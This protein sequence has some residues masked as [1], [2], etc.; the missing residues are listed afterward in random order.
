MAGGTR[1][2][3][4]AWLV[5][6]GAL[7]AL[8]PSVNARLAERVGGF[9]PSALVSFAVG[10]VALA[11]IVL[12]TGRAA[13]LVAAVGAPWWELTGGLIG[14]VYVASTIVAFPRLGTAGGMAAVIASQLAAGLL[15]DRAGAFG[16]PQ[17]DL[18]PGRLAGVVLLV[19]GAALV[20][21]R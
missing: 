9:L 3:L 7:S 1:L 21:R 17:A 12:A 15:L 19:A 16:F 10:T 5:V 6:V 20:L 2:A 4:V 8:Q 18:T 14:A 11:L 13:G